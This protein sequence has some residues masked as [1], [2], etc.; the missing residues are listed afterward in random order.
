M[1]RESGWI[2][3][4]GELETPPSVTQFTST[5]TNG[6]NT[7][8]SSAGSA[9]HGSVGYDVHMVASSRCWGLKGL[10]A[11]YAEIYARVYFQIVA[12]FTIS[13]YQGLDI[14]EIG[15][16]TDY[17][18]VCC[19]KIQLIND[20][21]TPGLPDHIDIVSTPGAINHV[22]AHAFSAGTPYYIDLH[23]KQHASLGAVEGWLNGSLPDAGFSNLNLN[24]SADAA[25]AVLV[26]SYSGADSGD[27]YLD[28]LRVEQTGPIG[29][30]NLGGG[31]NQVQ[32]GE[33]WRPFEYSHHSP[34]LWTKSHDL[35]TP[36]KERAKRRILCI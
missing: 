21:A 26:G 4:D 7:F 16:G 31:P 22:V 18:A 30:Y 6:S 34:R 5:G 8:T 19:A 32:Q 1:A 13:Q 25:N 23:Y 35:W 24:T 33:W 15:L 10:G 28:D 29:A 12:G 3:V 9:L 2:V 14:L 27:M 36:G 20:A 17:L 11:S